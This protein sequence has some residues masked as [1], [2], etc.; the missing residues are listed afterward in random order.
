MLRAS[1]QLKE[2][3]KSR[4]FLEERKAMDKLV[5]GLPEYLSKEIVDLWQDFQIG[6]SKEAKF[7]R[8]IDKLENLIQAIEYRDQLSN[9][10]ISP[11]WSQSNQVTDNPKLI[12]FINGLKHYFQ[13]GKA[14]KADLQ[15]LINYI[16]LVG[17][18]KQIRRKGWVIRGV[19]D[20]ESLAS[21][22]FRA[23]LI[24]WVLS[25]RR[26]F[27]REVV[28]GML[29]VH[30]LFAPLIGDITPYDKIID[31]AKN[32]KELYDTLPWLGSSKGKKV[33]AI[34]QIDKESKAIDQLTQNLPKYLRQEVKYLWL[35]YKTGAS[36]EARF[37]RQIDRIES[38]IQAMEYQ[39]N[40]KSLPVKAF[41][42]ELK[43]LIDD[44]LLSELVEQLD[45]YFLQQGK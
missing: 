5:K 28:L 22:S 9:E 42:L 40:E 12:R 7:L 20:P 4:R 29:F 21:H 30:D 15:N 2:L 34:E 14:K 31:V 41:W 37:A 27:D 8:E 43:E 3:I 16:L 35:E 33:L 38:V 39:K 24:A 19:K 26:R 36:K 25:G 45:Y 18:M 1:V 17:K 44:P 23:A 11:F 6:S 13:Q 32:K 10:M